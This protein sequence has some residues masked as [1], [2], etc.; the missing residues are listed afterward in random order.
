[1]SLEALIFDVDGTLAETE[2]AHREAFNLAFSEFRLQ[3]HWDRKRYRELLK[4]TGG[5]E[6]LIHY[7][8]DWPESGGEAVLPIESVREL[9][10]RKTE[11]FGKLIRSGGVPLRPGIARLINEARSAGLRLA[12]ATTTSI[13]NLEALFEATLG[14]AAIGWFDAIAAGDMVK[15]KKPAPDVYELALQQLGLSACKCLAIED[16]HAGLLSAAGAGI[17]VIITLSEYTRGGKFDGA[18]AVLSDLG[19]PDAPPELISPQQ[20]R[21]EPVGLKTLRE[22]HDAWSKAIDGVDHRALKPSA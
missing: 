19:T 18:L 17:P 15:Q 3:W 10:A 1:M 6:R 2:E 8:R 22:W 20:R 7:I 14:P 12:I 13:A 11:I 16:A 4:V 9:H 21:L 5:K